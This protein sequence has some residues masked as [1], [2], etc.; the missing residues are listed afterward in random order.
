MNAHTLIVV[1]AAAL[2][3][4]APDLTG[5]LAADRTGNLLSPPAVRVD[6]RGEIRAA[7]GEP[8]AVDPRIARHPYVHAVAHDR[9]HVA[10][11][12][13][14]AEDD[15]LAVWT[16]GSAPRA[17][18]SSVEPT[19]YLAGATQR[20][21]EL[22]GLGAGTIQC[23]ELRDARGARLHGPTGFRTAPAPS[24]TSRVE[25]AV[26]GDSGSG[27]SDQ[28][29]VAAQLLSVPIDLVIHVG[30]LAYANG[31]LPE[32]EANHFAMYRD[33]QSSIPIFPALGD[34]DWVTDDAGP[35]REVYTLPETGG[36]AA[37][38]R[39]YSFDWGTV[40]VTVM[41]AI[42][43]AREQRAWVEA[44]LAGTDRPWR[45]VVA[46][47][48]PYSS[49]FHGSSTGFRQ[50]YA[51]L[52]ER[53]GVQLVVSGDDHDYER[54]VPLGGVTYLVTGGG[55]RSVRPVGTSSWTAFSVTAF[56]F[57]DIV[58]EGDEMRLHAIDATGRE[59]DGA[60]IPRAA[61]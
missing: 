20:G 42:S 51:P 8:G 40:H 50:D 48:P 3:G 37:G 34:H 26:L 43:G 18:P 4:C 61:R 55:G 47:T 14:G 17:L 27:S 38:E 39:W 56:H 57:V 31:T 28:A 1:A 54:T 19:R 6:P 24:D 44:D 35:Y 16:A 22:V 13:T 46:H 36:P 52:F 58:V 2:A 32:L 29:A 53:Y 23:Y 7:C 49:G 59:F 30:D 21:V 60:V 45:I 12:S 15:V 10:W 33:L 41:D 9:A 25:L 11:T 5:I